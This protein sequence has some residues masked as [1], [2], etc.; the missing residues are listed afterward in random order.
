M[1]SKNLSKTNILLSSVTKEH[2]QK[3]GF[4]HLLNPLIISLISLLILANSVFN[5]SI[6]VSHSMILKNA[7]GYFLGS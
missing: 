5:L 6:S 7:F 2:I 4:D 3:T 1:V